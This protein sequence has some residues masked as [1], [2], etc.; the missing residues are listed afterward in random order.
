MIADQTDLKMLG[1]NNG[2]PNGAVNV[3][4]RCEG[5]VFTNPVYALN[6]NLN[7]AAVRRR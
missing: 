5:P 1:A 2:D 7:D 6:P 3:F 4:A